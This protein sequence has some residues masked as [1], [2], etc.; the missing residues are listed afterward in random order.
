LDSNVTEEP[1]KA[2]AG[3]HPNGRSEATSVFEASH[4]AIMARSYQEKLDRTENTVRAWRAGSL[5]STT[6]AALPV[7]I[8]NPGLPPNLQ[9]VAPRDVPKRKPRSTAGRVA[10]IHSLAHIEMNAVNLAWDAVYRFRDLPREY[11]DDW[12][13]VAGEE[14]YHFALLRE[15]LCDFDH[16]YGDLPAHQGLWEMAE[17]T[18]GDLSARMAMVP[19]FLEARGLDVTPNLIER[20]R[21][22]GDDRTVAILEIILRDEIRHVAIGTKWFR[23][24]CRQRDVDPSTEFPRLISIYLKGRVKGPFNRPDREQA[25]FE[26]CEL[27]ALEEMAALKA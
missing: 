4:D 15:R 23:F 5:D 25:G 26:A 13:T 19:R 22:L 2:A 10:L 12:V 24:A 17:K 21:S 7:S 3:H 8:P 14:A 11:Y 18:T 16:D 9:L 20:L 1:N 27:Q 6:D